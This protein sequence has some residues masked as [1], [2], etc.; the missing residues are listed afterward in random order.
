MK[1]LVKNLVSEFKSIQESKKL[2]DGVVD[3]Y[4]FLSKDYK[5]NYIVR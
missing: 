3:I 1:E 5:N 2:S 4:D